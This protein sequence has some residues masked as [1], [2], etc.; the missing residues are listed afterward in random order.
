MDCAINRESLVVAPRD[1]V[2][3]DRCGL[4]TADAATIRL[5]PPS[6]KWKYFTGPLLWLI[7]GQALRGTL[8]IAVEIPCESPSVAA[9]V[10][11]R[12]EPAVRANA[13]AD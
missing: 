7:S 12:F 5:R 10:C 11:R 2:L 9:T 1:M 3:R 8:K 13:P 6:G 4:A